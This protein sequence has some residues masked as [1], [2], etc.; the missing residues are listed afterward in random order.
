MILVVILFWLFLSFL[1]GWYA[2]NKGR[3]GIGFM[4]LSLLL[5]PLVG[6][7]LAMLASPNHEVLEK[8]QLASGNSKKCP[9]CAEVVKA[10]A[11]VCRFCGRDLLG[12][13]SS[14]AS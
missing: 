3:T 6:F 5:S 8:E 1:V 9:Y 4:F 7:I 14:Q 13:S 2:T 10:E 11:M 12:V